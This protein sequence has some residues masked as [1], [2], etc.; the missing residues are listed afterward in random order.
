MTR[1][2][3][4]IISARWVVPV[5]P[6]HTVLHKQAVIIDSGRIIDVIDQAELA[7]RYTADTHHQLDSHALMPGLIN[8]HAHSAMALLR[9]IGDDMP[10]M[11]WLEEKIWPVEARTVSPESIR[12]GTELAIAEMIRGGTTSCNDM[13]FFPNIAAEAY[14]KTGMRAV[15]GTPVIEFPTPWASSIDE[16]MQ[17]GIEFAQSIADNP[18][19]GASLSPHAPYTVSDDSFARIREAAETHDL[20]VDIHLHETANELQPSIDEYGV[21]PIERLDR[22]GILNDRLMAVHMTQLT[23]EEIELIQ[24]RGVQVMHC[25]V[26]NLKLASGYC[27]VEKLRRAGV[28]VALGTDGAASNND[29][30]MFGEM[31]TAALIGKTVA[32]D[33]TAVSAAYTIEMATINGARALGLEHEIGSVEV[34][35]QADLI[36]IDMDYIETRPV[37]DLIS[38]LVYATSRFQVSHTWVAGRALMENRELTTLDMAEMMDKAAQWQERITGIINGD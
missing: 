36:A 13:Y 15:V 37:Y 9:G 25:P 27:P 20:A 29:L 19:V 32:N 30:D 23:D 26:S 18:L 8:A 11:P 3:D 16:Y 34:G 4:T 21:R 1:Q 2:V 17:R 35:K 24:S 5:R 22:L 6:R 14:S 38:H 31:K 10:L 33:A 12:D 7:G 28:N